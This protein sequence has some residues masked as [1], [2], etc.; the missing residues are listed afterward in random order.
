MKSSDFM[1]I[2]KAKETDIV[3]CARI[4]KSVQIRRNEYSKKDEILTRKY[5]RRY[6]RNDCSFVLVAENKSDIIGYI[7]FS[8]DEWNNSFHI[9]LFYISPDKQGKGTG[10]RLLNAVFE[11][12]RKADIRI[13]FLETGKRERDSIRFYKKRGFSVAG[14]IKGMYKEI[15]GDAVV[16]SRK[17]K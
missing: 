2:R 4:H 5:L 10:S 9:D 12:A 16:L 11:R 15:S 13:I 6:L 3:P 8:L 17:I 1:R 7:V 14:R